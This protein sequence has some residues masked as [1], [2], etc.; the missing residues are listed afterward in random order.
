MLPYHQLHK[1]RPGSSEV[2]ESDHDHYLHVVHTRFDSLS[3][4]NLADGFSCL[5][6]LTT[7]GQRRLPARLPPLMMLR[8]PVPT[9]AAPTANSP[10]ARASVWS[11]DSVDLVPSNAHGPIRSAA[12]RKYSMGDTLWYILYLKR[13]SS[14]PP[15][16]SRV[17]YLSTFLY[18]NG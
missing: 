4:P 18:G 3:R 7:R 17:R 5:S 6:M 12:R 9:A 13:K 15:T 11:R 14:M 2:R 16:F 1:G 10:T 8:P